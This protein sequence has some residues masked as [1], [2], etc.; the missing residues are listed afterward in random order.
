[1]T[2][3]GAF[4]DRTPDG[5]VPRALAWLGA[6][7]AAALL[8]FALRT[9]PRRHLSEVAHA[10]WHYFK[11][12]LLAY[13]VWIAAFELVGRIAQ[14]LPTTDLTTSWDRAIPLLP[15]FVW[16]YE[17]GYLFPLLTLVLLIDWHRFNVALLAS[18][19]ANLTAFVVYIALPVAFPRPD[20]G[21]TLA[22]RVLALEYAADFFPGANKVPSMHVAMTWILACAMFRQRGGATVSLAVVAFAACVSVATLFVKQHIVLD[23]VTGV[24]WGLAAWWLAVRLYSRLIDEGAPSHEA[25]LQMFTLRRWWELLARATGSG[26]LR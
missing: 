14:R 7:L 2:L 3:L 21:G 6:A 19:I 5:I 8:A 26:A 25:L 11:V 4:A 23:V 22:E 15:A 9:G 12:L 10:R 17:A 13:V 20:L 1:M 18:L 16:A 24:P